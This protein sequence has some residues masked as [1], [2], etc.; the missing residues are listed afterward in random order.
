MKY[1]CWLGIIAGLT[2]SPS[3]I[4]QT[5]YPVPEQSID[6]PLKTQISPAQIVKFRNVFSFGSFKP[7]RAIALRAKLQPLAEAND[8]V[9]SYWLAKT[10]DWYEFGIGR[11]ADFQI[12]MKWYR[13]AANLNYRSAAYFLYE[14]YFYG[15]GEVKINYAESIKWLNKSL[16]LSSNNEKVSI[17]SE[18]A[19]LSD[20]DQEATSDALQRTIPRDRVAHLSYLKQA[21]EID[22]P[23]PRIADYYGDSLY[24]TKRYSEA[25]TILKIS[26]NPYTWRQIGRMYEKGEGTKPDS[27]QAL[28]WYKKMAIE[29][30]QREDDLNPIS[31]YG[32][33]EVYRLVCLKKVTPKQ[34]T[35]PYTPKDYQQEFGRWSDKE[36]N[37]IPG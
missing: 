12:A 3:S 9:A 30:K 5:I 36:C 31:W 11:K 8:P 1:L 13:Q 26:D 6:Y 16:V 10:Y 23:N 27:I 15:Y 22:P 21:F 35:P 29:G 37:F 34:V 4:A 7:D 33:R 28:T 18:F 24:K 20:P 25:L 17:L 19:R 32:K 14:L 2:L